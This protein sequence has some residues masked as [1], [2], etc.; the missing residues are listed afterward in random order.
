MSSHRLAREDQ[1]AR[2]VKQGRPDQQA[3]AEGAPAESIDTFELEQLRSDVDDV[4]TTVADICD[5]LFFQRE[6]EPLRQ[7]W[8]SAC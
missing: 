1:P 3:H 7:I 2:G 6:V 5:E 8:F 4:T